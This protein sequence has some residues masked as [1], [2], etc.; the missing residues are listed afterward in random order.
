ML[1]SESILVQMKLTRGKIRKLYNKKKQSMRRF[2]NK[3]GGGRIK[4]NRTFRQKRALNLHKSTLKKLFGGVGP[5]DVSSLSQLPLDTPVSQLSTEQLS[6]AQSELSPTVA[7]ATSLS[8]LPSDTPVSQ[9]SSEQ[10]TEAQAQSEPS[11]ASATSLSPETPVSQL[12]D[13]QLM[14]AQSE[15]S[16]AAATTQL[17][18][19]TP[20]GQLSPEQ[21]TEAQSVKGVSSFAALGNV[22]SAKIQSKL[23][24]ES[25]TVPVPTAALPVSPMPVSP[26]P[27][28]P[29]PVSPMPMSV[30]MP[31]SE[32]V[33]SNS[34]PLDQA[35]EY[36]ADKVA[37]KVSEKI[38]G[39]TEIQDPQKAVATMVQNMPISFPSASSS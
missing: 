4:R 36:I 21:L 29:M 28:S 7:S 13:Q 2:K 16:P 31:V 12:S 19:D 27:V 35:I 24:P 15:P 9:L 34:N 38:N 23:T 30:G 17:S 3:N 32:Q 10:L 26:M 39:G 33:S 18:Q 11:S 1:F 14:E 20:V 5:T 6:E 8:Q 25:S 37:N 22:L